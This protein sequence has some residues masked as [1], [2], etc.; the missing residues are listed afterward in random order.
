MFA[1]RL[2]ALER[3]SADT[4]QSNQHN[5][6]GST[7]L[8]ACKVVR[9]PGR[10]PCSHV[11]KHRSSPLHWSSPPS[12]LPIKV[13]CW[14]WVFYGQ[15]NTN[16]WLGSPSS[17]QISFGRVFDI[18]TRAQWKLLHTWIILVI[19]KQQL[20]QISRIDG[21]IEYLTLTLDAIRKASTSRA[22][23]AHI[24]QSRPDYGLSFQTNV[25]NCSL[26]AGKL[27]SHK[28]LLKSFCKS[29]FSHKSVNLF[30]ILIIVKDKLTDLWGS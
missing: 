18:N 7:S 4:G 3:W 6:S 1:A 15:Y 24:R 25:A 12:Y 14:R 23:M 5:A 16:L 10:M 9:I 28:V 13:R 21:P 8:W 20:V 26:F 2:R 27:I 11:T 22:N 29:Q 17:R 19:V 30:F